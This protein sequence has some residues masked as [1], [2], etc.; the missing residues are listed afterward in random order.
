[1]RM[2]PLVALCLCASASADFSG[3]ARTPRLLQDLKT[4][5][6]FSPA[7]LDQVKAALK[8]ARELPQL[9]HSEQTNKEKTLTW[10]DYRPLHVMPANISNGLRFLQEQK[11]WLDKA[12]ERY[13][14]PPEVVTALLGVE[15]KYG[16]FTG[17]YRVLDSL[18]TLGY[19]HPSRAPF[20]FGEL[21]QFF[22][23]CRDDRL[24]PGAVRG[25]YAGAM[26]MAQFMPSNYRSLAV[27]FDGDGRVDL[28]HSVPDVL[29]S[30]ANLLHTNGFK[31]GGSY[32][33]GSANFEA[34]REWNHAVIYRK[35]IG[36]FADR[37][38][39]R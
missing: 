34:M 27:D 22:V 13:G 14:V 20:F 25:S 29:A 38:I 2:L 4:Q 10:E 19:E 24:D 15:T 17:R 35:T 26:G 18:S 31:M 16:I 33:E 30:T 7:E 5:Y 39:G 12:Q 6:A 11:Q 21:L 37:L 23:L 36:Y 9:I 28:R 1:M 32:E 8:D 3:D